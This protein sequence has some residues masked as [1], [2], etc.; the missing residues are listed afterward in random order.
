MLFIIIVV[1]SILSFLLFLLIKD[2]M[3]MLVMNNDREMADKIIIYMYANYLDVF[4][5]QG[6]VRWNLS[7][8]CN[9]KI[10]LLSH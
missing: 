9:W 7:P 5:T 8:D 2:K 6:N 3:S 4:I 1:V 10:T